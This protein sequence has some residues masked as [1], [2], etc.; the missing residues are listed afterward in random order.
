MGDVVAMSKKERAR[1]V[2]LEQVAA[3][4]VRLRAAAERLGLS[5]RQMKRVWRRYVAG[6]AAGLVHRSRGR[7]S[8]RGFGAEVRA[9]CVE[10]YQTRL[11]GFGPTLA[12]EKLVEWGVA[13]V[14]HETLRRWLGAE[15]LWV[16]QRRRRVH[17]Q[18]RERKAHRGELVQMDGSFHDWCGQGE[19]WCLMNLVD[20]A[21]TET[22]GRFSQEETSEAA[23]RALWAWI[24]RHGVP[25]ALYTDWKTVYLTTRE[26]RLEEELCGELPRTAFGQACARLGI[27][28][29]GASSPQAKGRVERSHGVYQDRLVKELRLR[30]I[31]TMEAANTLLEST[32]CETLNRKF[33]QPPVSDEDWHRPLPTDVALED[34]FVFETTRSVGNDWTV[35]YE[36]RWF[37]ITGPRGSLPPA[38]QRVVVRRHLDGSVHIL[39]RG[40]EVHVREI[41]GRPR[42]PEQ[43][44]TAPVLGRRP[45][46]RPAADHPW[47]HSYKGGMAQR[48]PPAEAMSGERART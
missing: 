32:F 16:R 26:P 10:V 38:K 5:Y 27:E 35:R 15:G 34:V 9:T 36:G 1:L 20:D 19:R 30:G 24:K 47:R 12:A 8:N 4:K 2:E 13:T 11:V 18:W 43:P 25:R 44:H 22:W 29:I 46:P 33:A 39:Y 45:T 31:T 21:T 42:R 28:I 14:D 3:G 6:G 40:H 37:Q 7:A 17:R 41:D 48:R 23:M